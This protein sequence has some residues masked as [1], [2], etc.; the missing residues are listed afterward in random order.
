MWLKK[1]HLEGTLFFHA[2]TLLK[3]EI[4]ASKQTVP[5]K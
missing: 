5:S 1:S 4:H 2:C 3:S